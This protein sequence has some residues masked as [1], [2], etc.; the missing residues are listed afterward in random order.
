MPELTFSPLHTLSEAETCARMMADSEPWLTLSRGYEG[1]LKAVQ[2]PGREVFL[3]K[4]GS[5]IAGL[6]MINLQGA[7]IGY[8]QALCV[9]PAWRNKGI[10]AK[11]MAFAEQH[12]F[13]QTPN[14]FLCVSSFNLE[15]QKFYTRQD[16][17]EIGVLKDY[18]MTGYDEILMRKT[19]GPLGGYQPTAREQAR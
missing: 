10:G 15:A 7:F 14:V 17:V 2:N 5:E 16:Y 3:A 18:L 11:L 9:A 6:V 8:I 12:I 1:L 19:L 4:S 13:S